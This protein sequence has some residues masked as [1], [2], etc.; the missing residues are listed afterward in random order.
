[1]HNL[2]ILITWVSDGKFVLRSGIQVLDLV[3][4][5]NGYYVPISEFSVEQK[6]SS[7]ADPELTKNSGL[8]GS[9]DVSAVKLVTTMALKIE[10]G[11]EHF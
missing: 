11:P 8:F 6:S 4:T 7:H 9:G 5:A 3:R 10:H 1:M 2:T